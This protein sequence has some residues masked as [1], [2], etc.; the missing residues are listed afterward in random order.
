[1]HFFNALFEKN[2]ETRGKKEGT[3]DMNIAIFFVMLSAQVRR[4]QNPHA[5]LRCCLYGC[6]LT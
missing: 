4:L 6:G 3:A 1:M 5:V 2:N